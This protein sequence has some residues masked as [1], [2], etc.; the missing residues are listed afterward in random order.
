[1]SADVVVLLAVIG[2]SAVVQAVL[3]VA[4]AVGGRRVSRRV[5]ELQVRLQDE[6]QPA[7]ESLTRISRSVAEV[8]DLAV[9]Q[10]RRVES[11]V[12]DTM[13]RIDDARGH[14]RRTLRRPAGMMGDVAAL[15]RGFRRGL[16]VYGQLGRLKAHSRGK[17][18]RYQDDEHLFI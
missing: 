14:L 17:A 13:G 12:A 5:E 16:D 8:T 1:V 7:V 11:A 10:A 6:L 2:L 18:R 9:L 4:L 15:L 3:L